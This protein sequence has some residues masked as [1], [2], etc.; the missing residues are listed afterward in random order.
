MTPRLVARPARPASLLVRGARLLDPGEGLDTVADL[1]VRDGTI[2]AIGDLLDAPDVEELD[3]EGLTVLPAFLDPHVHL[4]VP[5]QEHKED[6]ASGTRAAAAGGYGAVLTMPN[7]APVIDT[8]AVLA[9]IFERAALEAVVPVGVVPAISVGLEGRQLSEMGA[10]ADA[11]AAGFTDDGRPVEAAGLLRRAFAYA[12]P[13]GV[14]IALHEQDL[15]LTRRGQMHEGAVSAELGFAGWPSVAESSM[16]ARDLRIAAYEDGRIHLQHLSCRASVEEVEWARDRGLR[17]S[18]EA[19]PHHLLLTDEAVRTLDANAKMNPPLGSADD[20]AALID[21][22]RSG[23]IDCIATDHAPHAAE[24]KEVP[25]EAAPFGVTGLETAFPAL[26][27]GLVLPGLLSLE[28]VVTRL[29]AGPAAAFGLPR[30]RLA[31]GMP[32]TLSVW[33]L[34]DEWTV[35]PERFLSRSANS[36]FLG[37]RLRGACRL[38][39]AEGRPAFHEADVEAV[40]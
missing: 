25:F 40:R 32:A 34:E 5:G 22:V 3:G 18:C 19:S 2:A 16:V 7:T 13:L 24:E 1:L 21:G 38:T 29:T 36:A 35:R 27:T 33:D 9:A 31:V 17:V 30:P 23:T 14:P 15:S 8:P 37:Q 12:R 4:R 10:L 39:L 11:G 26:L 28:T 20:R 6:L